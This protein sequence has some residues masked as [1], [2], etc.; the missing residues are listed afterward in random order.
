MQRW[1]TRFQLDR[2]ELRSHAGWGIRDS[3][4]AFE[5]RLGWAPF[6]KKWRLVS[7]TWSFSKS[8]RPA[9]VRRI[10]STRRYGMAAGET[11]QFGH[12]RIA[13][14][15]DGS[16]VELG[17]GAMGVTYLAIDERLKVDVALKVIAP[18]RL[19]D[20]KAESLF[21]REAR[22]AARVHQTNV[23]SV[24]FLNDAP[25]EFYY[26]MEFVE[27]QSLKEILKSRTGI[28][29]ATAISVAIQIARGLDAIHEQGI[30]HRDLKPANIMLVRVT[31]GSRGGTNDAF[32]ETWKAK[33]ID[34]GLARA[35]GNEPVADPSAS[36][37]T[38]FR[39]TALY[40]SPEQCGERQDIDGRSDL[41][42]LGCIMFEMFSG[43]P[44]FVAKTPGEL[45]CLH[46]VSPPPLS[47]LMHLPPGVVA[48]VA[49]LLV[50]D[51]NERFQDASSLITALEQC[52]RNIETKEAGAAPQEMTTAATV[53]SAPTP[54]VLSPRPFGSLSIRG[55]VLGAL[56]IL[57]ITGLL[58]WLIKIIRDQ[59]KDSDFN[60]TQSTRDGAN[61]TALIVSPEPL[62]KPTMP[63]NWFAAGSAAE[64]Y[65]MTIDNLTKRSGMASARISYVSGNPQLFGTMMQKIKADSFRGKR[66]M[67]AAWM[68]TKDAYR[69]QLWMRIDGPSKLLGF[70]NM[71][72]RPVIG[73]SDW[74]RYQIVL[75][76]PSETQYVAFGA[77]LIGTGHLWVDDFEFIEVSG[78]VSSTNL[79][80]PA[81]LEATKFDYF[82]KPEGVDSSVYTDRPSNLGFEY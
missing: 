60:E 73:T 78:S 48:V 66:I 62:P 76:V 59:P 31:K 49:R 82:N 2:K 52:S 3:P 23:A 43:A 15:P 69:A 36:E 57:A 9:K 55:L 37:T 56:V 53:V 61:R 72:N 1:S 74:T 42:S 47:R 24:V 39:G 81:N 14:N 34:F 70:D 80:T 6:S 29:P 4:V 7:L 64:N 13:K 16:L 32:A 27:G 5:G 33:I 79:L 18:S 8:R 17:R 50:K 19:G 26:A 71:G 44:P 63:L 22:A 58:G 51:P 75:D 38:G 46:L 21:L 20:P 77:L 12:F 40:A 54:N 10:S 25:G 30:I 67:M 45:I 28:A 41:Y 68:R 65:E 35:F 11:Q